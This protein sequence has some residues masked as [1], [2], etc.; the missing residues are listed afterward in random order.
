MQD[1]IDRLK[2]EIARLTGIVE[3]LGNLNKRREEMAEAL[4]SWFASIDAIRACPDA[5]PSLNKLHEE[6]RND[7]YR[8]HKLIKKTWMKGVA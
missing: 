4:A 7:V 6:A 3:P 8:L 2:A 5:N 1:E